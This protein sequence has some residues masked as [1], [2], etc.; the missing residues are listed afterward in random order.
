MITVIPYDKLGHANHG[1]LD[2]RHHFSFARYWDPKRVAFGALRVVNDDKVAPGTGFGMHPHDNMEII[3]YVRQ[4]AITHQDSMGNI[5]RTAAGDVQVMSAGTG[6]LHSEH[7]RE[8]EDTRLYQIWII[9]NKENVPPRW[10]AREFPKAF[11][12]EGTLPVL[13]SGRADDIAKGALLIHQDAA[14]YGGRLKAGTEIRQPIKG[15]AYLLA[16]SGSFDVNGTTLKQGDGAEV[17]DDKILT[18]KAQGDAEVLVIDVPEIDLEEA[19]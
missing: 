14:I 11:L 19:A 18:L 6:V 1:W 13:A 17:V 9:P 16:S 15:K 12:E 5:G 10:E 8:D 3:T 4:G 7:N 2:A